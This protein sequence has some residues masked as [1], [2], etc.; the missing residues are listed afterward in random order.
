MFLQLMR[1]FLPSGY[2][3]SYRD[4]RI[5]ATQLTALSGTTRI[6]A[7]SLPLMRHS[8][9]SWCCLEVCLPA[10]GAATLRSKMDSTRRVI[11]A[12]VHVG[13]VLGWS[14]VSPVPD[15][16]ASRFPVRGNHASDL[17]E[18]F[19]SLSSSESSIYAESPFSERVFFPGR[20]SVQPFLS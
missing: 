18:L 1:Q 12:S 3:L 2:P 6:A 11:I 9:F 20:R 17:C 16:L 19:R 14:L 5:Y 4:L 15:S 8:H 10:T 13:I 7:R